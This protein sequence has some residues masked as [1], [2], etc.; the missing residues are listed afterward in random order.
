MRHKNDVTYM[1]TGVCRQH[2]S[3]NSIILLHRLQARG[4]AIIYCPSN[5]MYLSSSL[6]SVNSSPAN[7]RTRII[8]TMYLTHELLLHIKCWVNHN[9]KRVSKNCSIT[10]SLL[11][12]CIANDDDVTP[13]DV[14]KFT[15]WNC[16]GVGFTRILSLLFHFVTTCLFLAHL[17][18][19]K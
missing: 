9:K 18:L 16:C 14:K 19:P 13:Y 12:M 10:H 1:E 15:A 2:Y 7:K 5:V 3:M 11:R 6:S 8:E 4:C 17:A